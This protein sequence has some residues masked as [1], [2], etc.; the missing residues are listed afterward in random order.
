MFPNVSYGRA[1]PLKKLSRKL[2][3]YARASLAE[4]SLARVVGVLVSWRWGSQLATINFKRHNFLLV[5]S[6]V[7]YF[8][9]RRSACIKKLIKLTG[10]PKNLG[11]D[12]LKTPSAILG[13]IC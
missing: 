1:L 12:P 2:R 3:Q 13:L 8:P 11:V 5:F 9:H 4:L 7:I 10:V 6:S